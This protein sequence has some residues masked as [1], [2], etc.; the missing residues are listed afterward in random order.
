ME[1]H[2]M[3]VKV[4]ELVGENAMTLEDGEAVYTRIL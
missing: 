1:A 4:K 3:H 2:T